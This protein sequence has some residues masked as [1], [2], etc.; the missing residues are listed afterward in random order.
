MMNNPWKDIDAAFGPMFCDEATFVLNANAQLSGTIDCCAFPLED[1]DPF[2][3]GDNISDIRAVTLLIKKSAWNF[4]NST[5]P[6]VGDKFTLTDG[7]KYKVYS[8]VPEQD[9]WKLIGRSY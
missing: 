5:K 7:E 8:I 9:W 1:V 3:E 2:A 6:S 4:T